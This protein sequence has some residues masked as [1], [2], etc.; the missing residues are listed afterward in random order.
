MVSYK[1]RP[2]DRAKG[3]EVGADVYLTKTSLHDNTF[4]EAVRSL[5]AR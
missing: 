3:K 4:T 5:M 1:D 2:E